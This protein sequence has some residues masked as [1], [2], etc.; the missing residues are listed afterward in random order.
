MAEFPEFG[1]VSA[2]SAF[3]L[4][5]DRFAKKVGS[6]LN[7]SSFLKKM[8]ELDETKSVNNKC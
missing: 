7:V 4:P 3:A 6:F 1:L 8:K 2:F 5:R